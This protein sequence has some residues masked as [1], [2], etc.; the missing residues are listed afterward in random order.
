TG[1]T[2]PGLFSAG[3][4][5][6]VDG[7]LAYTPATGQS[8]TATIT[9]TGT[10]NGGTANGGVDASSQIFTITIGAAPVN[11]LPTINAI[12]PNPL[13]INEDASQQTVNFSGVTAGGESQAL[14]VTATS[15]NTSLIP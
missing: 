12:T 10:D 3:P 4:S 1:N 7:T 5:I 11:N 9:V 8:G 15:S 6:A 2:N 13:N 14:T